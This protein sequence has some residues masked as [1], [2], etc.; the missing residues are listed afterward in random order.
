[1]DFRPWLKIQVFRFTFG[2][3]GGGGGAEKA[4]WM[5]GL[6]GLTTSVW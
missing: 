1:M 2:I 6:V 4:C 3:E 5:R